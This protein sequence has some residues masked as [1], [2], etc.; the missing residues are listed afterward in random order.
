MTL[1]MNKYIKVSILILSAIICISGGFI[2]GYSKGYEG[3]VGHPAMTDA[4]M[5]VGQLKAIREN[6]AESFIDLLELTLD[7][8]ILM[9][10]NY[11]NSSF[12]IAKLFGTEHYDEKFKKRVA[13]YRKLHPSLTVSDA[14]VKEKIKKIL[15]T[16]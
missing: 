3:G 16:D 7:S 10:D 12:Q 2:A 9:S 15:G 13:E 5:I 14:R 1:Q 6:R 4:N 11:H 8:K